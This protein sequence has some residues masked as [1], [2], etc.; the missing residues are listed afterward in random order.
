MD[1]ARG[2]GPHPPRAGPATT[3]TAATHAATGAAVRVLLRSS[4]P[5]SHAPVGAAA[6]AALLQHCIGDLSSRRCLLCRPPC[7]S[8]TSH[9]AAASRTPS[10]NRRIVLLQPLPLTGPASLPVPSNRLLRSS[11]LL[12]TTAVAVAAVVLVMVLVV[13]VLLLPRHQPAPGRLQ[14]LQCCLHAGR[15]LMQAVR[16]HPATQRQLHGRA[17][18]GATPGTAVAAMES[19]TLAVAVAMAGSGSSGGVLV[20]VGCLLGVLGVVD[21]VRRGGPLLLQAP[22]EEGTAGRGSQ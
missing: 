9:T 10:T 5:A 21:A 22:G 6:P 1:S 15:H 12:T 8:I 19:V 13:E 3:T 17:R 16:V 20:M 2:H 11:P 7:C 18:A 14:R 4:A